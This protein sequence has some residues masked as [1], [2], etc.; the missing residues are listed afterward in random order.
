LV[1]SS[2]GSGQSR[3]FFV[4][5]IALPPADRTS[6]GTEYKIAGTSTLTGKPGR[7]VSVG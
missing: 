1:D 6:A 2:L 7:A 5:L 4:V 3:S